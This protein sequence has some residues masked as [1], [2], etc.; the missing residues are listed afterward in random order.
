MAF[1][2]ATL[3]NDLQFSDATNEKRFSQLGIVDAVADSTPSTSAFL[4]PSARESMNS[5]SSLRNAQLPVL[6]DQTVSVVTTPGF[7]FIPSNLPDSD[8]YSFTAYDV[9]SG[10]RFYPAVNDNN[11]VDAMW[12]RD[13]VMR[14]V[15]FAMGNEIETILTA[16]LEERKTQVLAYTDQVSQGDGTFTFNTTDDV[17]EVSKAAQKETMFF[18]LEALM[19]ANELPGDYRIVTNRAGLAVKKSEA[20]KYGV[21][22]EKNLQALG[23]LGVDRMYETGNIAAGGDIFN[24]YFLRDGAMGMIENYPYDFRAGTSLYGKQWSISDVDIP[25]CRLRANIYVD[26]EATDATSLVSAGEDSN[27]IM[28]HFE[29]MAIWIRFYVVYPYN[30]S[31]STRAQDIVSISGLTT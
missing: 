7:S 26:T 25:F 18:N 27:L 14:N 16:R 17:L 20:A 1:L 15:A 22:N 12:Q 13:Q 9:F 29:E 4:P 19:A 10:F 5:L 21:G 24:G 11:M 28:T 23:M 2:D 8:V 31:L 6:K 3:W 30:S